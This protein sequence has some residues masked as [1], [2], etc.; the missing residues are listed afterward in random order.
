M[1]SDNIPL[2]RFPSQD[3]IRNNAVIRARNEVLK[4]WPGLEGRVIDVEALSGSILLFFE[5]SR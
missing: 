3:L 4:N 1:K 5:E 2:G